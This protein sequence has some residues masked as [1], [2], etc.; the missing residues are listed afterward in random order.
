VERL[1]IQA[2]EGGPTV[3]LLHGRGSGERQLLP[4]LRGVD[5]RLGALAPRAPEP[6][7]EGWSWFRRHGVGMP[8]PVSLRASSALLGE[9]LED[10]LARHD[11]GRRIVVIGYSSGGIMAVALAAARP[12]LVAALAVVRGSYPVP[13]LLAGDGLRGMPVLA[14]AGGRDHL[15][16]EAVLQAGLRTYRQAGA[17]VEVQVHP[18]ADHGLTASDARALRGWLPRVVIDPGAH[19]MAA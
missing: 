19:A 15:L 1:V 12:D 10:A 7:G 6:V 17:L 3:L 16:S 13:D 9:W 2:S 14:L 18:C 11:L 4:L 5:R 8:S